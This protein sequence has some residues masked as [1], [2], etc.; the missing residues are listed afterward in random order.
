MKNEVGGE[1]Q[2]VKEAHGMDRMNERMVGIFD[3]ESE[4]REAYNRNR[5]ISSEI[6]NTSLLGNARSIIV[7][8]DSCQ[9]PKEGAVLSLRKLEALHELSDGH[10]LLCRKT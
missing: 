7:F 8:I 4:K 5:P 3:V 6:V 1:S 9:S 10:V 2:K